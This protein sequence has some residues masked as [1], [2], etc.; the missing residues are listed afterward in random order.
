MGFNGS[1]SI[2][3]T[4]QLYDNPQVF[5]E[6]A[7]FRTN[8]LAGGGIVQLFSPSTTQ[9]D[10]IMYVNT[11][12]QLT[13]GIY[14]GTTTVITSPNSTADDDWHFGVA[15][16]SSAGMALYVDNMLVASSPATGAQNYAGVWQIGYLRGGWPEDGA[17]YFYGDIAQVA[18]YLY[19]FSPAQVA[20]HTAAAQ[21]TTP[22]VY[23]ATVLADSPVAYWPLTETTGVIAGNRAN[24]AAVDVLA[25]A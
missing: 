1:S 3:N 6:T 2:I 7:R 18:L 22:G 5:T 16:L 17:L 12:G 19:A 9:H 13:F 14:N 15:I 4:T 23:A 25:V 11:S 24:L 10:R 8:S 20:A 21:S